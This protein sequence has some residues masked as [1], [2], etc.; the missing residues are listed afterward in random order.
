L[1]YYTSDPK[2]K[3]L[4][5]C[6]NLGTE[7]MQF[8][9]PEKNAEDQVDVDIDDLEEG[10]V[11]FELYTMNEK[12]QNKSVPYNVDGYVYRDMSQQTWKNRPL[13]SIALVFEDN[14]IFLKIEWDPARETETGVKLDYTDIDGE[15]RSVM[16]ANKETITRILDINTG[17]PLFCTTQHK[18]YPSAL[19][20]YS[21]PT[22]ELQYDPN[23]N[24]T[25]MLKNTS[26]PFTMG[27]VVTGNRW[28]AIMDW[29]TNPAVSV[30]GNVD[31]HAL[32]GGRLSLPANTTSGVGQISITNGKLYQSI[33][34]D[35]GTY[36]FDVVV[37]HNNATTTYI[38]ANLGNDLPDIGNVAAQ[39]L[40]FTH[41]PEIS[42]VDT[43][44]VTEFV[45]SEKS[46]VSLG[47]V[48]TIATG[49]A[50]ITK[51]ELWRR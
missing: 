35:A 3:N 28:Y 33:E 11:Y 26:F 34:L 2:A 9:I 16:V 25:S 6:W 36:S 21:A 45:L 49:Q 1:R 44:F 48:T 37:N 13:M 43:P 20:T 38:V 5:V 39:A 40:A 15:S 29:I 42:L 27:N 17:E 46:T 7:S 12:M 22:V 30:N 41:L 8:A 51:V 47:F 50:V 31:T 32:F 18:L 4:L 23:L 14:E 19:K 24:L 10:Y